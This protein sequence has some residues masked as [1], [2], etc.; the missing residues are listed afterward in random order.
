MSLLNEKLSK[1]ENLVLNV[2][3]NK[4]N[5]EFLAQVSASIFNPEKFIPNGGPVTIK[6]ISVEAM[7]E[8]F[9]EAKRNGLSEAAELL[10]L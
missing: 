5:D 9:Q 10:G 2:K 7:G 8:T 4:V 3:L 6:Q 1:V